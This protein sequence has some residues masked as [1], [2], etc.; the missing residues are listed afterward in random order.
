MSNESTLQKVAEEL[1]ARIG[2]ITSKYEGDLAVLK[3]QAQEQID[4]L[5]QRC[6]DLEQQLSVARSIA[7]PGAELDRPDT[8]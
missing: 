2:Q 3:T 6:S 7:V 8:D 1:A 4:S 5:T